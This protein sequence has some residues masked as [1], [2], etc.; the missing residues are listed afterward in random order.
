MP[1]FTIRELI[2]RDREWVD[3]ATAEAWGA[4]TVAVHG[5]LYRP[6][7]LPGFVAED[8][9]GP[10]GLLTYNIE[11]QACEVVTL[12]SW[13]EGQGIGRAL[14]DAVRATA[15]RR[16]CRR[17]WLVTTNDNT[18]ALRFYQK[19]GLRLAA[20]HVNAVE[21]DRGLK[22][23]IPLLGEDDIPIRDEIEL[24]LEP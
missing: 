13:Q 23:E 15:R 2:P 4:E 5:R 6:S 21:R 10:I 14:L 24:E 19:W 8:A 17:L 7:E 1:E 18:Q 9:R 3:R 20:L 12:N 16:G 22:P 11:G